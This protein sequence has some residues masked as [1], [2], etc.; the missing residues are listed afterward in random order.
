[1]WNV[2]SRV[3]TVV[4]LVILVCVFAA[5]D[6]NHDGVHNTPE[7][8]VICFTTPD[9]PECGGGGGCTDCEDNIGTSD[10][11]QLPA[12]QK[13][14]ETADRGGRIQTIRRT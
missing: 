5:C 10:R 13:R 4:G 7:D 11:I 3:M 1:M 8:A 2:F 14:K 12:N 9:N 6:P